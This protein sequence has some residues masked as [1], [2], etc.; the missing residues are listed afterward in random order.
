MA[1]DGI[2]GFIE[3]FFP[4]FQKN[5]NGIL[6]LRTKSTQINKI[7]KYKP[8]DNCII[9]FSFTPENISKLI[10]HKTPSVKKRIVA[11]KK[12]ANA[13]WKLGLRFD[14]IIPA[15]NFAKIYENLFKNIA[16]NINEKDIHSISFGMMRFPKKM[17]KRMNKE[18][19]NKRI[20]SL[21]LENRKGIYTYKEKMENK[22]ENIIVS[23]LRKYMKN[24]PIYN[25]KI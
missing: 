4:I 22:L 13:G 16:A 11:M 23:K 1:F 7:L 5:K 17:F 12:L 9:A 24:T 25:C 10:E 18:N 3:S 8:I 6:E 15:C 20:L 2:T 14:P 19:S 21:S